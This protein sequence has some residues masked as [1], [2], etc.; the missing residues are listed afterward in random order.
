MVATHEFAHIA[1]LTRPSRNTFTRQLWTTLP[2]NLGPVA[3]RS[4]RWVIEG[5]ATYVEGR[6]THAGRPNGTW[7]AAFLRQWALE[8][9][10]PTYD[11]LDASS[12]YEGRSFA[13]LAGSAFLEWLV[14]KHGDSSLVDVWRRVS[15][16]QNRS[17]DEAFAG[18]FGETSDTLWAFL[19]GAHRGYGCSRTRLRVASADT[20]AIVQ[21]TSWTTGDPAISPDGERVALVLR[22]ATKPSRVVIWKT[23][24]EPDTG[25]ARRDSLLLKRD[26]EDVVARSIYPPPKKPLATLR[27]SGGG[28]YESPRFL[29]DGRVLLWRRAARGD[30]SFNRSSESCVMQFGES[31]GPPPPIP[32]NAHGCSAVAMQ[33]RRG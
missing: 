28:P 11:Q 22:S 13:Y 24:P 23:A 29:R 5:Y 30:G 4:P 14:A 9:Q 27:S 25:R 7:R 32:T 20:G 17:F 26:P 12:A 33:C 18:V 2:V 21:R 16:K 6:V 10:L 1:H 31:R 19:R 3:I 15:A 8:G